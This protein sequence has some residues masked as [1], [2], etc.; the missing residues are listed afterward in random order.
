MISCLSKKHKVVVGGLVVFMLV[1]VG[2]EK[3]P[4]KPANI[5]PNDVCYYCK[6]PIENVIFAAEFVTKDGFVR[7]FDDIGCLIANA[8]KIGKKNIVAVYVMD[9]ST[10]TWLPGNEAQLVRSDKLLT[11][12]KGGIVAFQDPSK[13]QSL[14][15]RSQGELL[16]VED[17]L[18]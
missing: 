18:K 2:C 8:R 16:K 14:A 1:F 6:S 12:K 15:T 9:V 5:N 17:L 11:P 4:V 3:A 10:K 7:K 13:A